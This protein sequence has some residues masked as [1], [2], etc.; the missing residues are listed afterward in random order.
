MKSKRTLGR[1]RKLLFDCFLIAKRNNY[2]SKLNNGLVFPI[3]DSYEIEI[4]FH[5]DGDIM[6]DLQKINFWDR[7]DRDGVVI[8]E[9][10]ERLIFCIENDKVES[11][12]NQKDKQIWETIINNVEYNKWMIM[13]SEL[14]IA[15]L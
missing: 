5:D 11:Y 1:Y 2:Q 15:V 3:S 10:Y 7:N 14:N 12:P 8:D 4:I 6:V 13:V 9:D